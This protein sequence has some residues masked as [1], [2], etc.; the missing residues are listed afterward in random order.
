MNKMLY[1]MDIE[2]FKIWSQIRLNVFFLC[3]FSNPPDTQTLESHLSD[4]QLDLKVC[5]SCLG[6]E[7]GWSAKKGSMHQ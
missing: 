1:S 7:A 3:I 2:G 5:I 6:V 4:E